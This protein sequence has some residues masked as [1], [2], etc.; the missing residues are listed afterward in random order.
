MVNSYI[1]GWRPANAV[2]IDPGAEAG[3]ILDRVEELDLKIIAII[4]THGHGDHIGGNREIVEALKAPLWIGRKD[5]EMLPDSWKNMSAPFGMP[6][7]SPSADRLLKEGDI[8]EIG[9]G[10]IK[11]LDAPGH[12]PGS[13]ILAGDGFAFVGDVLFAG[14]IGRTDFPGGSCE[15]L[16]RMIRE[17]IIPLG[18]KT[19]VLPGHGPQSTIEIERK[20]NPFLQPGF[21]I[22]FG[23]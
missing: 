6:V 15:L 22:G 8:L 2:I 23:M 16:V 21:D 20:T 3:R 11:V 14:S 5:A 7:T 4:N 12:S 17:K 10:V 1:L 9:G 18:D 13:I 19:I